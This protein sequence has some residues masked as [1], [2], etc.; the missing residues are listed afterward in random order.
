MTDNT[1]YI[2]A[3]SAIGAVSNRNNPKVFLDVYARSLR[4]ELPEESYLGLFLFTDDLARYV[5]KH[6]SVKKFSDVHWAHFLAIDI[7]REDLDEARIIA[8][9]ITELLQSEYDLEPDTL[10][11]FFSGNKGFHILIPSRFFEPSP[12]ASLAR[13]FRMF[14]TRLFGLESV[15]FKIYEALRLFRLPNTKHGTSGLYKIPLTFKE[16]FGDIE[17]ILQAAQTPRLDFPV[18][19]RG[20]RNDALCKIY[21][22]TIEELESLKSRTEIPVTAQKSHQVQDKVKVCYLRLMDGVASGSRN[23]TAIRLA[24]H[25][26]KQGLLQESTQALLLDWDTRNSPSFESEGRT[27]ELI[28]TIESAYDNETIDYGCHDPILKSVCGNDCFLFAKKAE[29]ARNVSLCTIEDAAMAYVKRS[30]EGKGIVFNIPSLDS[31]TRGIMPGHVVQYLACQGGGKTAFAIYLLKQVSM[32]GKHSL[33]LS[34]EMPIEEVFERQCQMVGSITAERIDELVKKYVKE[35]V[36]DQQIVKRLFS[37]FRLSTFDK[38]ITSDKSSVTIN[39]IHEIADMAKEKWPIECLFIDYLG[40]VDGIGPAY[41]RV[42][43]IVRDIKSLAKDL[44]IPI[45]YLNQTN[46]N[47]KSVTEMPAASDSRDSGQSEE[48]ADVIIASSRPYYGDITK[49]PDDQNSFTIRLL[50]NRR[51]IDKMKEDIELIFYPAN[52]QFKT[53]TIVRPTTYPAY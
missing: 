15:D 26:R 16:L 39:E 11:I 52:M 36:D 43:K 47:I 24:S 29:Q 32:Q 45:I 6:K 31:A 9:N 25:F 37:E 2:Y 35:G 10:H 21:Q 49:S 33:F 23:E 41:E 48:A 51:G 7:D 46:R 13:A 18:P 5:E 42:S 19:K 50:K 17:S 3:D 4:E 53:R 22:E 44:H 40:R 1:K 14:C 20:Q 38:V 34:L 27:E 8:G 30:R 28:R 12:H